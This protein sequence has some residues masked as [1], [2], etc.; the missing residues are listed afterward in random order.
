MGRTDLVEFCNLALRTLFERN[1]PSQ[2]LLLRLCLDRFDGD[3]LPTYYIKSLVDQACILGLRHL[4]V[5]L[6]SVHLLLLLPHIFSLQ[7]LESL[8]LSYFS[9][10]SPSIYFPITLTHLKR[11]CLS[12]VHIESNMLTQLIGSLTVLE[13]LD[14]MALFIL[15]NINLTSMSIR[16]LTISSSSS[17]NLR[18]SIPS[19]EFLELLIQGP[20]HAQWSELSVLRSC[21]E[22]E[23]SALKKAYIQLQDISKKNVHVIFQMLG[24]IAHVE[25][26]YLHI[27]ESSVC[28]L[29]LLIFLE[30]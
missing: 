30:F 5:E 20:A 17:C 3:D 19:L 9:L 13:I 22:W 1:P 24:A 27:Q 15:P 29:S 18:I 26:L 7:D 16:K 11:L 2:L 14:L 6:H 28:F 25:E 12:I 8:A 10:E 21:S 4:T 23:V